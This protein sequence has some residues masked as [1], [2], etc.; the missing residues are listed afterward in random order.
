[1]RILITD[2]ND[3][4]ALAAARSLV[5]AGHVVCVTAPKPV[6][7]AGVSRR[8]RARALPTD[9]LSDPAGYA[10]QV[11]RVA[12]Q[13]GTTILLPMTDPSLEAMLEQRA[14][15]PREVVLP[16]P[17]LTVYRSAS[18]KARVLTLAPSCGFAVPE[19][20]IVTSPGRID[21][22]V[23]PTFF[24]AVVKPHR[25]VVSVGNSRRKLTVTPVA[26]AAECRR[27][28]AALPASA[29]PVLVQRWVSGVGEGL[30]ALRWGGRIVALFA[31]RR[32]REKPPAGGVSV[33]RESIAL[34]ERLVRPG[35]RLLEALDWQGVAMIECKRDI[36]TGRHV[37]MEVNGRFWGS[38][39]LAIDAGVDFPALLVRC[40][41]GEQ[42]P[43][44]R[45]YRIGVRSRWFWGD[46]DHLLLR[47]RD[48]GGS[49][50]EAVRDFLSA[51]MRRDR[52]EVWRWADPL[53]FA[54]ETLQWLG[55]L[56]RRTNDATPRSRAAPRE[57]VPDSVAP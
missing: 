51:C 13:E 48:G 37:V 36:E 30:F 15:L 26:N 5:R 4:A 9:A 41:V 17:D 14:A 29:F 35:V 39:Q 45:D 34:D 19:S 22:A 53:P 27:A 57:S 40:A 18:D 1:M 28:L 3:R 21:E 8:V 52:S 2:G 56:T 44:C 10:A 7:L 6:S 11:R 31:H 42:V 25:S 16:F 24:P 47:L 50:L 54:V 20:R 33:Y 43:E 55:I 46:V 49:R 12:E 38:L 32:L 23:P